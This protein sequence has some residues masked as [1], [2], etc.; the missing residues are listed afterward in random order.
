MLAGPEGRIVYSSNPGHYE[1]EFLKG[2]TDLEQEAFKEGREKIYFSEIY[3]NKDFNN[4]PEMLLTAPALD[5]NNAPVGVI[6]FKIDMTPAYKLMQDVTGL[7]RT[8][9]VLLGKKSGNKVVF[10]NPLRHDQKAAL[11]RSIILGDELGGPIQQAVKSNDGVGELIDYRGK[12]VLA[13]WHYLPQLG[14]GLVTKI[15]SDEVFLGITR[16]KNLTIIVLMVTFVL[17]AIMAFSIARAVALPI[18]KLS[19]GVEI[20]GGGN[21]EHKIALEA[22]DEIGQ[23]SRAFD[24]MTGDL[25]RS[26][27]ELEFERRRFHEVLDALPAYVVLLDRDYHVPF[28][29]RYFEEHFGRSGGKR[30]YE[31]LFK[32]SQPCENCETY[33]VLKTNAPHHWEWTGPDKRNYDIFDFPFTDINGTSLILE[34]GIDITARKQAERELERHR[35][36]LEAL[37]KERTSALQFSL[38]KFEVLTEISTQLLQAKEPQKIINSLCRKVM[39]YLDC[40][41][42]FNFLVDEN[43]GKLCLNT[44]LGVPEEEARK[45]ERLDH[46]TA[47]CGAVAKGGQGIIVERASMSS[48]PRAECIKAYGI[49]AYAC[50]PIFSQAGKVIGTLSFGCRNREAFTEEEISFMKIVTGQVAIATDRLNKEESLRKSESSLSRSQQMAHLGSWELDLINNR[51]SWSDEVYRIFGLK[52][53]EF[54]ATYEAFLEVVHP[55][56]RKAVDEAYSG[57]L[58]EGKNAY[59]IEHRIIRKSDGQTRVVYEKCEHIG[60]DSGKIIRSI[61]MVHDI[62]E[63]KIAEQK[64]V[65]AKEEW[66]RTFNSVP[67]LIAILDA[68]HRI[69]QVNEAMASSLK[70]KPEECAGL[71]CYRYVH[72]S[73]SPPGSCPHAQTLKDGKQHIEEVHEEKLGG[74]FLVSTTPLFDENGKMVGSVHVA[75]N[76]TERKKI[77]ES[78]RQA[79]DYLEKL[80]NYANA[81]IICWDATFKITRFNHAFERLTD[82]A[83]DEVL[84][85]DL[86][87]L[88]PKDSKEESLGKIRRTLSGEHWEGVEIP[89]LRKNGEIRIALWNSANVYADDGKT[90]LATIA[91]GQDITARKKI[92]EALREANKELE[93]RVIERTEEL[94]RAQNELVE[95]KRLSDIGTLSATVAHELR[96]PLA[97]IKMATY[98]IK[99]K[100]NNPL[101]DRHLFNIDVKVSESEQIIDNLLFYSRLKM[102]HFENNNIYE[103]LNECLVSAV[104]HFDKYS[105]S[106]KK[107]ISPLRGVI[108][109]VDRLQI[110]EVFNNILNNAFDALI[111]HKGI[112]KV[113]SVVADNTIN[114]Y[115]KDNGEG[116][117]KEH[118]E[119]VYNPFFTTK[120]KGTGL[121]LSVCMQV[122][123]M[124]NGKIHIESE[125]G[126]GTSVTLAFPI[127]QATN[128]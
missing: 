118:L 83:A 91:Q 107:D 64:L 87:I 61:G 60:D 28:A 73:N 59:E 121:G 57:S 32:R 52:P 42:A 122:M 106:L 47:V 53:Q 81:P 80:F 72:G 96:N 2:L 18:R 112:I 39:E 111:G 24:K 33:K 99:R 93:R 58:R 75:R 13:A 4:L 7:G 31:Y 43:T 41:V 103:I 54:S 19:R 123:R 74:D 35:D 40:Q 21:L 110:T 51:L 8:G 116:I 56:D 90:L 127:R 26:M 77:E 63:T 82:Y 45:I 14:W 25:K 36:N 46:G 15:D 69:V 113:G 11:N 66:E 78:L 55:D 48:D 30:C 16:L 124:H 22:K 115:F 89:I 3:L 71:P 95:K 128:A 102:P 126:K 70:L 92:S 9:E 85:K 44:S 20:V 65:R 10:L 23:L 49:K 104:E 37:V 29:N 1:D 79:S 62:T 120:A 84:G 68:Q 27:A 105:V 101:L 17:A 12:K 5:L 97:A 76:I 86:S 38:R 98:N 117:E 34:M 109:E 125:K 94:I 114:I 108:A 100:A 50:H 119:S 88:F 6:A 67:D